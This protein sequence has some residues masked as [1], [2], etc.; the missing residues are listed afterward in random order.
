MG[1]VT[2]PFFDILEFSPL[3]WSEFK[4]KYSSSIRI[5]IDLKRIA[6][7]SITLELADESMWLNGVWYKSGTWREV[8]NN[9]LEIGENMAM[10]RVPAF[11]INNRS[12]FENDYLIVDGMHR[13]THY[14]PK[15]ILMDVVN[16]KYSERVYINDLILWGANK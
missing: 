14:K 5:S 2:Q 8:D 1:K 7:S 4:R 16:I 13:I 3:S 6:P 15:L 9:I 11:R 10:V 12:P